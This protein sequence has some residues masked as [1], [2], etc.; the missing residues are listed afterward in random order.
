M[1]PQGLKG[2]CFG[3]SLGPP[4][5]VCQEL[6]RVAS[7]QFHQSLESLPGTAGLTPWLICLGLRVNEEGNLRRRTPKSRASS[8][9]LAAQS[10]ERAGTQGPNAPVGGEGHCGG[11]SARS[12]TRQGLRDPT[13]RSAGRG[14]AGGQV[15][16]AEPG[17]GSGTE[18]RCGSGS[19]QGPFL[20]TILAGQSV[21]RGREGTVGTETPNYERH[22]IPEGCM[23][24]RVR[25]HVE[26]TP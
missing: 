10:L 14:T 15:L 3:R 23:R 22:L 4:V 26:T 12:G 6:H 16:E 24:P 18:E 9:L 20:L 2:L 21:L 8:P 19:G 1:P 25:N 13:L 5:R 7:Y 17:R 11:P